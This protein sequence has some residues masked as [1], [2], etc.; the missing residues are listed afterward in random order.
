MALRSRSLVQK[1]ILS[2]L[3]FLTPRL[4]TPHSKVI[5]SWLRTDEEVVRHLTVSSKIYLVCQRLEKVEMKCGRFT[6]AIRKPC[7]A[8]LL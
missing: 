1:A 3:V 6:S 7:E 4:T 8:F 5:S 2:Y